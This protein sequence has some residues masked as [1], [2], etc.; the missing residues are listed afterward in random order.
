M[1]DRSNSGKRVELVY[2]GDPHTELKAGDRGTIIHQRFD[3]FFGET[4]TSIDWDCGSSLA[5]LSGED[6]FRIL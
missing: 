4:T 6:Q 3:E 1:I 2:T 5:L